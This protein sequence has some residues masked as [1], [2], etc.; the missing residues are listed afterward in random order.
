MA[1]RSLACDLVVVALPGV[2]RLIAEARST[3]D[4]RA[5]SEIVAR[6]AGVIV[7]CVNEHVEEHGGTLVIPGEIG[8][9][10]GAPNRVVA[11]VPSGSGD[12]IAGKAA[13]AV[14]GEWDRLLRGVFDPPV[15]T[16]NPGVPNILWVCV[17]D[18]GR[19]YRWQWEQAQTLLTARR[20]VRDFPG[21]QQWPGRAICALSGRWPAVDVLPPNLKDHERAT[22]SA[23]SWVK[24]RWQHVQKGDR[25]PSTVSIASAGFR[26]DVLMLAVNQNHK[27]SVEINA[28][29]AD[30]RTAVAKVGLPGE[31]RVRGLPEGHSQDARW[32]SRSAGPWVYPE[33]WQSRTL[34]ADTGRDAGELR[35]VAE[36]GRAA[37][38]RLLGVMKDHGVPGPT[39]YLAVIIQDLDSMGRFLS[40]EGVNAAHGIIAV[41]PEAHREV[42]GLLGKLTASQRDALCGAEL[43][44]VPVYLGGD[45]L[46]AFT[47]AS[48]ALAAAQACHDLVPPELPTASTAVLF[49]HYQ[50]GLQAALTRARELLDTAKDTV[51]GKHALAVAYLRRSGA[52]EH[53]I[54]PWPPDDGQRVN[55]Q[56]AATMFGGFAREAASP[57]SPRLVADL[58]RDAAELAAL[59]RRDETLYRAE[60]TRLVQRHL[61]GEPTGRAGA[62]REVAAALLELGRGGRLA[63]AARVGVF[64]RQ[65]AR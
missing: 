24:R 11:L 32:F 57:L 63:G 20:R 50:A 2:Q 23:T 39:D 46:L 59:S 28:A 53:S 41:D 37:L 13:A 40:G 34:A 6:L 5:G 16:P 15:P 55:G 36:R 54:Q 9:S 31:A 8:G 18:E 17:P 51:P 30:L 21:P 25:F 52:R 49:F 45:D 60:I 35:E 44:G 65:E 61:G 43:L 10:E 33:R 58:E 7:T 3:A 4:V 19:G 12:S 42:S 56:S 48:T 62:A 27:T 29:I 14:R 26:R 47:P 38:E 1:V 64:L 22:L